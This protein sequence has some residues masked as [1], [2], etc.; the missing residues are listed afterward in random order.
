MTEMTKPAIP[1]AT[2]APHTRLIGSR[3]SQA[4]DGETCSA[5]RVAYIVSFAGARHGTAAVNDAVVVRNLLE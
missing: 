5:Q 3:L 1:F 4:A 2:E